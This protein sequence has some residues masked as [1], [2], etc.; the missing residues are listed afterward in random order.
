[1]VA[2]VG[3]SFTVPSAIAG[4]AGVST[5]ACAYTAVP[6]CN[7]DGAGASAEFSD[8]IGNLES[9]S[10]TASLGALGVRV[11]ALGSAY[12]AAGATW[13]DTIVATSAVLPV[14][15]P[16]VVRP[17]ITVTST[18][19]SSGD[20]TASLGWYL[21]EFIAGVPV[22]LVTHN[23]PGIPDSLGNLRLLVGGPV[24]LQGGELASAMSFGGSVDEDSSHTAKFFLDSTT[25]DVTLTGSTGHDYST[26]A[27]AIV[28]EPSS[29]ALV[30]SG[31][32][33]L[34]LLFLTRRA[35]LPAAGLPLKA[36]Y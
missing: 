29:L 25:L 8:D 15:T 9:A 34:G 10:A 7:I 16:V 14:G 23:L 18:E 4:P 26:P 36:K 24:D 28:P 5:I 35:V 21:E 22:Y 6:P 19:T 13:E 11:L 1:V 30:A 12:A 31:A 33:L 20:A 2:V 17:T 32:A 27:T 3:L